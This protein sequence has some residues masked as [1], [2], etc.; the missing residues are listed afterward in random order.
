M[1]KKVIGRMA[2][3]DIT[4]SV[5]AEAL[6]RLA[7]AGFDP[8]YGARPLRRA[9]QAQVEDLLAEGMLSGQVSAGK[10]AIIGVSEGKIVLLS[11]E[12]SKK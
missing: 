5:T 6:E 4:V 11:E 8:V 7:D 2:E 12:N 1:L 3:Q 10:E 9:I